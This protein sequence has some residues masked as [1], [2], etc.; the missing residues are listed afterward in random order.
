MKS[1]YWRKF[2]SSVQLQ[3]A[4]V[5]PPLKLLPFNI[6]NTVITITIVTDKLCRPWL[7]VTH[8]TIQHLI[9]VYTIYIFILLYSHEAQSSYIYSLWGGVAVH[10]V[11]LDKNTICCSSTYYP[12]FMLLDFLFIKRHLDRPPTGLE[13]ARS[14]E[15]VS[16]RETLGRF[17]GQL[18]DSLKNF[19]G[20]KKKLPD[21]ENGVLTV[22]NFVH[23]Y[24]YKL[25]VEVCYIHC[26]YSICSR[27]LGCKEIKKR[28]KKEMF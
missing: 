3:N 22:K 15:A 23:C 14:H 16:L 7:D 4:R 11:K 26:L 27:F 18:S 8:N 2:R 25:H 1:N 20:Q 24:W 17:A 10:Y 28:E 9:R 21:R 12:L 19:A 13:S 5:T 6:W